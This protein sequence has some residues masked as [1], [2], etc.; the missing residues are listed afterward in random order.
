MDDPIVAEVRKFR[1]AHSKKFNYNVNAIF[2]DYDN[3]HDEIMSR[4]ENIKKDFNKAIP[5][6]HVSLSQKNGK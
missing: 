4:I 6:N 3:R 1:N 2:K 5:L